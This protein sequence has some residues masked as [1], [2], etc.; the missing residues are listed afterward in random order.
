VDLSRTVGWFTTIFPVVLDCGDSQTTIE[1]LRS[2]KEQLRAI[3]NRGIGYGL[4]RYTSN[5]ATSADKLRTLPQAEVRF[6]YL[7][8]VDRALLDSSMF[9][10]APYQTGPPQSLKAERTYLLNV[11]GTVTGG[12][13]RLEWTYSENIHGEKTVAKLARSYIDELRELIAQSRTGEKASYS[14]SDFPQAKLSQE[15]LNKVLARL[16]SKRNE[17]R[18]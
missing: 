5:D 1:S 11:I 14:P 16:G 13:L 17:N 10:V 7:G 2:V 4:L 3:P 8:Q 15:D 18:E 12:E 6:N 9:T